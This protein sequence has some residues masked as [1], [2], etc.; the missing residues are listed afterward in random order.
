MHAGA[1][2]AAGGSD[3]AGAAAASNHTLHEAAEAAADIMCNDNWVIAV[4]I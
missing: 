4:Q 3:T 1:F 2:Q